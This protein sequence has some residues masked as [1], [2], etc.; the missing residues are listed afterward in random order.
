M[1]ACRRFLKVAMVGLL[2]SCGGL[3]AI[4]SPSA[5]AASLPVLRPNWRVAVSSTGPYGPVVLWAGRYLLLQSYGTGSPGTLIDDQ[6]S[7]RTVVPAPPD[8]RYS[9]GSDQIGGPWLLRDCGTGQQPSIELYPLGG[10]A[11]QRAPLPAGFQ[12]F[13]SPNGGSQ[14]TITPIAV[15]ADWIKWAFWC[16]H[17]GAIP[18]GFTN[19]QTGSERNDPRNAT[20]IAD[21]NTA[22]LARAVCKP[23]RV[24]TNGTLTFYSSYALST[25]NSQGDVSYLERC[26]THLHLRL[27]TAPILAGEKIL[28]WYTS[29]RTI[30]AVFPNSRQRFV[31]QPPRGERIAWPIAIGTRHIYVAD[32]RGRIWLT[33]IPRPPLA[34][35]RN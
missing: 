3:G 20:T 11:W 10:G 27:T 26:G 17:C 30:E 18:D 12:A 32:R 1:V 19:I 29:G 24:P 34:K 35:R 15:G 5:T 9:Y 21:L 13:C 7:K 22:A 16:Y 6:T 8:C 28:A 33:P 14:C 25:N 2:G 23:L 4:G 31:L